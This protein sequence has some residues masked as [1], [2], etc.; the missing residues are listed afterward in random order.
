[1]VGSVNEPKLTCRKR[2]RARSLSICSIHDGWRYVLGWWKM[3]A[4]GVRSKCQV[5]ATVFA[6]LMAV[7]T[8]AQSV[9]ED[10]VRSNL[11]ADYAQC[12]SYYTITAEGLRRGGKSDLVERYTN[13]ANKAFLLGAELSNVE[14]TKA[15]AEMARAQ[16]LDEMRRDFSN[17]E[18]LF[19][20]YHQLCNGLMID[21]AS[22]E[23]YW[24]RGGQ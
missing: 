13:L 17:L 19:A 24:R 22:R 18:I 6:V 23:E 10:H 2:R 14:V 20:K 12:W 4:M 7:T 15:R 21:P 9:G 16:Q 1:M 11:A 3:I 5:V 8:H